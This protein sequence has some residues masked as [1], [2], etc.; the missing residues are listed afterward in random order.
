[1]LRIGFTGLACDSRCLTRRL[2]TRL[3][4]HMVN[5][6]CKHLF[7]T[8]VL[9]LFSGSAFGFGCIRM[10][11]CANHLVS[12]NRGGRWAFLV[13]ANQETFQCFKHLVAAEN[14][15]PIIGR[16][17][18]HPWV[19]ESRRPKSV[20]LGSAS[21]GQKGRRWFLSCSGVQLVQSMTAKMTAT[22]GSPR[23]T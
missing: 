4:G 9:G 13:K 22:E 19:P 16:L 11:C 5:N 17:I 3:R 1:M 8:I 15:Q 20:R 10:C 6:V 21:L 23:V 14:S 7:M 2:S 12:A 18:L